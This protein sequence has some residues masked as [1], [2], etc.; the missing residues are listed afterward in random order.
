MKDFYRVM[1]GKGSMYSQECR[2]Q[3]FIGANFDI[4]QDLTGHLP[5]DWRDF[6]K[7]FI[8]VY[9]QAN[10]GKSKIGAGLSCGFLWSICKKIQVGDIVLS[11]DGK[12][13]YFVG[14]VQSEYR[15]VPGANQPHQRQVHWFDETIDRSEMTEALRRS[16]GSIGTVSQI[17]KYR[18]ELEGLIKG[19][20]PKPVLISTD[21]TI[22]DPVVFA[23][24]K[25]LED[26]LIANWSQ[27]PLGREYDIY[28]EEENFGQQFPTDTGPIDIL[29]ISKDKQVVLV[30]ELKKGRASDAVVGQIQRYM[31]YIAEEIAEEH[32][33]V[34]GVIIAL[35]DDLRIKRALKVAVN[36]DF[37][38]YEV[39]FDL[40]K[41]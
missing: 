25:H 15:F 29:A 11:P 17:S 22:E 9:L 23:L 1:L 27:T 26:F 14:E 34:R 31:G 38:R 21:E 32:Q 7:E 19:E 16:T 12:G 40:R 10:P 24:E 13:K 37:Y 36:I 18:E 2:E 30:V 6:N 39:K 4:Q 8:P 33:Q 20:A 28:Q 41:V 3:G 35:E 5:E